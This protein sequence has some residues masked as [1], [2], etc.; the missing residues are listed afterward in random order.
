MSVRPLHME[1]PSLCI[2]DEFDVIKLNSFHNSNRNQSNK[3]QFQC[4][5][6]LG[7]SKFKFIADGPI[8]LTFQ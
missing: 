3:S 2:L 8:F 1:S 5:N 6:T 7:S 4:M